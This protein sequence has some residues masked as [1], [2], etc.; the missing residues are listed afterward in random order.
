LQIQDL[1]GQAPKRSFSLRRLCE[2]DSVEGQPIAVAVVEHQGK[3]LIGRRPEQAALAGKWEFPGGKIEPGETPQAAAVRE[4]LEETGLEVEVVGEY[5]PHIERYEHATVHL[6]FFA[7]R[8]SDPSQPPREPFQWTA[9]RDLRDR[10]FPSG[11]LELLKILLSGDA[12]GERQQ[13]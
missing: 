13:G 7:C 6:R 4:C 8:P 3:F 2:N 9:R 10:E 11:N 12:A 1:F 5:P